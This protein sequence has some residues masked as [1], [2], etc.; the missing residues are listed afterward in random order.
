MF[1]S[2]MKFGCNMTYFNAIL[3]M[4]YFYAYF[5]LDLLLTRSSVRVVYYCQQNK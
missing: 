3:H 4:T 2:E 5:K 1:Y